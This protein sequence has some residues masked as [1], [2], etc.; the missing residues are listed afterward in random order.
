MVK[1]Q[2]KEGKRMSTYKD[3]DYLK[4]T[5]LNFLDSTDSVGMRI[6]TQF[7][8][9]ALDE[10]PA[11]DVVEVVRCKDCIYAIPNGE[12]YMCSCMTNPN[13]RNG[14]DFCNHGELRESE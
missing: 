8:I 12:V 4:L 5:L 6:G 14:D 3:A 13:Y 11:A 1:Q 9:H 10:M 7:C 2:K